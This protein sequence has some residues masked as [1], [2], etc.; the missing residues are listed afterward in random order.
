MIYDFDKF[1]SCDFIIF[2]NNDQWQTK[3]IIILQVMTIKNVRK[4]QTKW[5]FMMNKT[6]L[7][8]KILNIHLLVITFV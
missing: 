4:Y 2:P 5:R 8:Y 1:S 6:I 7:S 3:M